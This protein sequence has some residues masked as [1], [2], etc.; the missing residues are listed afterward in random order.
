MA[1]ACVRA[2]SPHDDASYIQP[3]PPT[4]L[5]ITH[6]TH[7]WSCSSLAW[8]VRAC[9]SRRLCGVCMRPCLTFCMCLLLNLVQNFKRLILEVVV[10]PSRTVAKHNRFIPE[11]TTNGNFLSAR[12]AAINTTTP[13]AFNRLV[14]VEVE[15]LAIAITVQHVRQQIASNPT[16]ESITVEDEY[17]RLLIVLKQGRSAGSG[18]VRAM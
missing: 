4:P 9:F 5:M 14:S 8:R 11:E 3:Q 15:A 6:Y 17:K 10:A 16:N 12:N 13:A 7:Y 18:T 1:V 2:L